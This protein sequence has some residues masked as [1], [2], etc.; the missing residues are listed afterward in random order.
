MFL[1][2]SLGSFFRGNTFLNVDHDFTHFVGSPIKA[3]EEF[4]SHRMIFFYSFTTNGVNFL[5]IPKD[6]VGVVQIL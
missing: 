6:F 4:V 5:C 2:I 1:S 3:R